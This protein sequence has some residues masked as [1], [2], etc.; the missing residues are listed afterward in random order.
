MQEELIQKLNASFKLAATPIKESNGKGYRL[1]LN[2]PWPVVNLG[3][4]ILQVQLC[5]IDPISGEDVADHHVLARFDYSKASHKTEVLTYHG[6]F[7]LAC[8]AQMK[9][10]QTILFKKQEIRLEYPQNI[11]Y[12]KCTVSGKG[13]FRH[14]TLESNCWANCSGKIWAHFDGHAQRICLP[15]RPD[16]TVRFCVPTSGD[17]EIKVQDPQIHI[18]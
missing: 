17:V 6:T 11:P 7:Y 4:D 9:D 12:L 14:V 1:N 18:K 15:V 5:G 16:K 2:V 10:G 13:D 8:T 3:V